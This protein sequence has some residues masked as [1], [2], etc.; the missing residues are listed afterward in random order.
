MRPAIAAAVALFGCSAMGPSAWAWRGD[1][2]VLRSGRAA[3]AESFTLENQ[4]GR[5]R[6]TGRLRLDGPGGVSVTS[7]KAALLPP[8]GRPD[9]CRL[10]DETP[11]SPPRALRWRFARP[12]AGRRA[13]AATG[14]SMLT[15]VP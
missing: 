3:G 7:Y 14:P 1:Y 15:S 11:G 10:Q 13:V 9:A 4:G 12:L 5:L 6:L 8:F 2:Q